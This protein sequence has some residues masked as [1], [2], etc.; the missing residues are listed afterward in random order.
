MSTP[1]MKLENK[2]AE[3]R[4]VF[5]QSFAAPPVESTDAFHSMLAIRVAGEAMAVR[6]ADIT[7]LVILKGTV[8]PVPSRVPELAGITGIRGT[9]VPVFSLAALLGLKVAGR[10]ARW[11]L[12]CGQRQGSIAFAFEQFEKHIKAGLGDVYPAASADKARRYV[13]ESLRH[14]GALR[15]IVNVAGIVAHITAGGAPIRQ[16]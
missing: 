8:L 9:V 5:D 10:E 15:P 12:L 14:E 1:G 11:V 4:R 13:T 6:L 3:M 16:P 7:T 2:I